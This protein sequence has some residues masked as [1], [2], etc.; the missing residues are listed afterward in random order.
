MSQV[1]VFTVAKLCRNTATDVSTSGAALE[2][3]ESPEGQNWAEALE[4]LDIAI[5]EQRCAEAAQL[6]SS[7]DAQC[8]QPQDIDWSD[9]DWQT[10]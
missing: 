9:P 3:Q 10:R 8:A 5:A 2:W 7:A 6:L 4:D 1:S